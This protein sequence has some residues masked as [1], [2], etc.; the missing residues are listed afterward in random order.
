LDEQM[1][2]CMGLRINTNIQSLAAQR[3]LGVTNSAQKASLEKLASG[4]R[5]TKAA[6]DAAG[7]AISE[8]MRATIRS[9][10]QDVRNASD[11]ISMIQTAEGGMNEVGNIL[12]RF[13]ELSTQAASDTISDTERG[14]IDKEVQQLG[15]EVDRIAN[16]TEFNSHK[17]LN[18]KG[19]MLEFHIGVNNDPELDR[20]RFDASKTNVT[21]TQLGIGGINVANKESAQTNL[22]K[23]DDAIKQLSENRAELGAL[24]N[25]LQSNIASL[26]VYDQNVSEARSRIYDVDMA[27]ETAEM[28]KNNILSQ[29]GTAVLSQANQN[30]TLAL[31][32]LG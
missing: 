24:Q 4:S 28:T 15:Q 9:V 31:K 16:S 21:T 30:S 3:N 7:L 27:S 5:I 25:R 12:I 13:R 18:G 26:N 22:T 29:A 1:E 8:K 2:V 11:G 19:D 6:D 23:I 10:R 20:F 17:L 32:L 14:F